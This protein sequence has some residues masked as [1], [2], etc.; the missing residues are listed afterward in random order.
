MAVKAAALEWRAP[1]SRARVPSAEEK[2][3]SVIDRIAKRIRHEQTSRGKRARDSDCDEHHSSDAQE[4]GV[5]Y[6]VHSAA[7]ACVRTEARRILKKSA[8]LR[9]RS[10]RYTH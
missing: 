5:R 9:R 2:K 3:S 10:H 4:F 8:R 7:P 1:L 6:S